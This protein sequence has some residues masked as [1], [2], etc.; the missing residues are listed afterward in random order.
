V[1]LNLVKLKFRVNVVSERHDAPPSRSHITR[2]QFDAA[3]DVQEINDCS[4]GF[5]DH[6][7]RGTFLSACAYNMD[8][9]YRKSR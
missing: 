5:D 9:E 8:R 2:R 1:Y 4:A 7:K 3:A 6:V